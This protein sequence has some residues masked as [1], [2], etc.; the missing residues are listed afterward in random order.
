MRSLLILIVLCGGVFLGIKY[1]TEITSFLK[2]STT[3]N[4]V[5]K[6]KEAVNG[7]EE[8][9]TTDLSAGTSPTESPTK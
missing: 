5:E 8:K 2:W 3:E 7:V 4:A 9:A 1:R 6:V